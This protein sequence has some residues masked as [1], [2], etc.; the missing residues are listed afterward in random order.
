MTKQ[1]IA[2]EAWTKISQIGWGTKSTD[3]Q[4]I[5]RA[6][7]NTFGKEKVKQLENFVR[8]RVSDLYRAVVAYEAVH[9][10]LDI[11]SDDGFSDL[12]Y[13]VV[14]LGMHEFDECL[15]DP[16]LLEKR[17]LARDYKES[18]AY[19][20]QEPEPERTEADKAKTVEE[21]ATGMRQLDEQ[22][23]TLQ[24]ALDTVRAKWNTLYQLAALI[25]KDREVKK[26]S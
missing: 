1:L 8:T 26:I 20:F 25:E 13:H 18:F 6:I 16:K 19:C 15:S 10:D 4:E 21:L 2:E 7:Y 22:I 5:A 12:R 9:G 3:C 23:N 14:G 24:R 11:G 17:Y